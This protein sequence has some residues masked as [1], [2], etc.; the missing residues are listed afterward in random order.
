[1]L[2]L[3]AAL[4]LGLLL[5]TVTAAPAMADG[6]IVCPPGT[7]PDPNGG[8]CVI[9][10]LVPGG[11]GSNGGGGASATPQPV[12]KRTCTFTLL[13][14]PKD[15][16]CSSGDGWWSQSQQAYCKA[17]SPQPPLSDPAWGGRTEG[18][19]YECTRP[20]TALG[21]VVPVF[22]IWLAQPPAG[23]PPDPRVLA[24]QAIARMNLKAVSIG[25]VPEPLPGRVG[26]VGMPVW[27][28]DTN[29]GP[30]TWGPVTKSA[31]AGGFTVTATAK[32]SRVVWSMGDGEVTVCRTPGTAYQDSYG[33]KDSPDCGYT[34]SRQGRYVVRA[35]SYWT[36]DW[37]GLGRSGSIPLSFVDS[38]R[39]TIG[40]AQVLT[41]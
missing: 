22:Q 14:S 40:E 13:G 28:W 39:L 4:L 26:L 16:P 27:M 8:Q 10:V 7:I 17:A 41:Q 30:S 35:R 33:M 18:Q 38:V 23:A 6:P 5:A 15:M 2:R 29:P 11:A 32:V 31:S 12:A 19:I 36:V 34:Y 21:L 37:S 20:G 9:T 1:M 3:G 24:Q 25:I